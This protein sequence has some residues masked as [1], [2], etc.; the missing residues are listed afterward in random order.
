MTT[1]GVRGHAVL[2]P[3]RGYMDN[4]YLV[5]GRRGTSVASE[6]VLCQSEPWSAFKT[7]RTRFSVSVPVP[8]P[9]PGPWWSL[10]WSHQNN[11]GLERDRDNRIESVECINPCPVFNKLQT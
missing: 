1:E 11:F 6:E 10:K 3:Q 8:L 7:C 9:D 5:L 4:H 2:L